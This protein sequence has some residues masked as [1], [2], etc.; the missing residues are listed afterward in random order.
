[1]TITKIRQNFS[2]FSDF[3]CKNG[4][5]KERANKKYHYYALFYAI[6]ISLSNKISVLYNR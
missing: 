4:V 5:K 6:I 2:Y 3:P 1:M